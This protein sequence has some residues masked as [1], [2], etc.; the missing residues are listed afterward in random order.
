MMIERLKSASVRPCC[1]GALAKSRK[2]LANTNH[3]SALG[4]E[5]R[6]ELEFRDRF[7]GHVGIRID[8]G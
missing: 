6:E 7:T 3:I 8:V 4:V 5:F 1:C 2:H